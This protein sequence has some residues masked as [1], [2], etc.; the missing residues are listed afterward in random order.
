MERRY[1]N[2]SDCLSSQDGGRVL[3]SVRTPECEVNS[4]DDSG[5]TTAVMKVQRNV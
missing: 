1:S 4:A 3:E 2:S 5:E